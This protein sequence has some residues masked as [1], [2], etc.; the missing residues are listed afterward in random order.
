MRYSALALD[1]MSDLLAIEQAAHAYPWTPRVFED[2]FRSDYRIDG[3]FAA[4]A[5]QSSE[6]LGFSV[7]MIILDEWHLLNLCVSPAN[8]RQG[9][10]RYLLE[11]LMEQACAQKAD[12]MLLEVRKSNRAAIRLYQSVG[13]EDIGHRKGYYPAREGREDARVM[14]LFLA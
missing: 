13:F 9:V 7:A 6:L 10:G 2:C 8:Q 11:K 12:R 5:G 1:D 3:V 4:D 14:R